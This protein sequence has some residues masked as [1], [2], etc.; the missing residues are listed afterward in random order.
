[1]PGKLI[2]KT[3]PNHVIYNIASFLFFVAR[4]RGS[5]FIRAKWDALKGLKRALAKRGHI[6]KNRTVTDDDIWSLFAKERLL[7]RLT[8]RISKTSS[9]FFD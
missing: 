4:G 3:I 8:R 5:D 7:P 9:V 6:Q 1:M 2:I